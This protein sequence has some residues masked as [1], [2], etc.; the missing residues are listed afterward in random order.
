MC[1]VFRRVCF[2]IGLDVGE[3]CTLE[4]CVLML[5]SAALVSAALVSSERLSVCLIA[6]KRERERERERERGGEE[7]GERERAVCD[8][9]IA[10]CLLSWHDSSQSSVLIIARRT[11]LHLV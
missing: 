7:R 3:K 11:E 6:R 8:I 9:Y 1:F 2:G 5:S 4:L 10:Q